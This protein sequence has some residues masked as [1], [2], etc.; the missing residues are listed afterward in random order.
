MQTASWIPQPVGQQQPMAMPVGMMPMPHGMMHQA[1]P[2]AMPQ[3]QRM[4]HGQAIPGQPMPVPMAMPS[5]AGGPPQ[6]YYGASQGS[7]VPPP[8]M[9]MP[10]QMRQPSY[11]PAP[12]SYVLQQPAQ[13]SYVPPPGAQIVHQQV[14]QPQLVPPQAQAP[15]LVHTMRHVVAG[16]SYVPPAPYTMQGGL[17]APAVASYVPAPQMYT[18][19]PMPVPTGAQPQHFGQ[20]QVMQTRV[21]Q[22][23]LAPPGAVPT[24]LRPG[25]RVRM[26]GIAQ[27]SPY[28]GKTFIVEAHEF[29][30]GSVRIKLEGTDTVMVMSPTYLEPADGAAP[31]D[32]STVHG[33]AV[34]HTPAW[35]MQDSAGQTQR[36]ATDG[37][38]QT[39]QPGDL[40]QL[41]GQSQY[42]G[43]VFTV[44]STDVGD[45]RVRVNFQISENAVSRMAFDPSHLELVSSAAAPAYAMAPA[46]T[47]VYG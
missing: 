41:R 11:V 16:P 42:N 37:A 26:K 19:Q 36:A 25:E 2:M 23:V 28:F 40:V 47:A 12:G 32:P 13:G 5:G 34:G 3:V 7:Y 1:M 15:Q 30:S 6:M 33:Q 27:G 35:L 20:G 31:V 46:A 24:S 22:P 4:M 43:K 14:H 8:H 29:G 44:E 38:G 18:G 45:G 21:H 10:I 9:Q 17:S 39:L